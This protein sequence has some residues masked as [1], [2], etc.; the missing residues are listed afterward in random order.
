MPHG[1]GRV[2]LAAGYVAEAKNWLELALEN[3]ADGDRGIILA[4]LS[5]ALD[6]QGKLSEARDRQ[7]EACAAFHAQKGLVSMAT[8]MLSLA[9]LEI[10]LGR[11][12]EALTLCQEAASILDQRHLVV[13][14]GEA[15][16]LYR[17]CRRG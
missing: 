4:L 7:F 17:F 5:R 15:R 14:A 2:F 8:G 1:L 9:R 10:R 13:E 6:L 12:W 3:P 11:R 16:E